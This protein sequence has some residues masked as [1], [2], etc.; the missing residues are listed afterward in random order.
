M[1]IKEYRNYEK[2]EFQTRVKLYGTDN[3]V[4]EA[5]KNKYHHHTEESTLMIQQA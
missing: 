2:S 3:F 5:I 4:A 1:G